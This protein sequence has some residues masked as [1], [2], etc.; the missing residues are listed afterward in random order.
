M[1]FNDFVKKYNLRN[2]ATSNIKLQQV[3]SSL[4]LSDVGIYLGDEPFKTDI[5]IVNLDP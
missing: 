3:L 5:G 1:L 4:S 2:K